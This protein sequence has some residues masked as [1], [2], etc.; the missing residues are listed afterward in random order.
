MYVQL[1]GFLKSIYSVKDIDL[2]L[3]IIYNLTKLPHLHHNL[4]PKSPHPNPPPTPPTPKPPPKK[5][6]P[7]FTVSFYIKA[8]RFPIVLVFIL[9]LGGRAY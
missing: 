6:R 5:P 8:H 1:E 4:K 2:I 3:S 9:S 7:V